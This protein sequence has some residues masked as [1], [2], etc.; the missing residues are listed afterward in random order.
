N[1]AAANVE[2]A[3]NKE[4]IKLTLQKLRSGDSSVVISVD[5]PAGYHLNPTAPQ[6]YSVAIESGGESLKSAAI[7]V[8]KSAKGLYLPIR[9]PIAVGAGS[10]TARVSF[11]FVYCREDNTG[12]CRINTLQWPAPVE[13]VNDTSAS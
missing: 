2:V 9:I 4:E 10:A 6:R 3:P 12:T 8:D 5:L 13:V 7:N 11:T 1:Q